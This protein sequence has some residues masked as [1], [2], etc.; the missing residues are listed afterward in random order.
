MWAGPAFV[1][2]NF[3]VIPNSIRDLISNS[4]YKKHAVT[5]AGR[6]FQ[7]SAI[8]SLLWNCQQFE[9]PAIPQQRFAPFQSLPQK[10]I[11]INQIYAQHKQIILPKQKSLN[12]KFN[13]ISKNQTYTTIM[14][15][16]QKQIL[17]V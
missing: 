10:K 8:R 7:G 12:N 9:L 11:L 1:T 16:S 17:Y 4:Y 2:N 13:D 15:T 5:N 3:T 6:A 14:I